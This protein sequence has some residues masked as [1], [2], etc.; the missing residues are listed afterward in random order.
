MTE[1]LFLVDNYITNCEA[2]LLDIR[3]GEGYLDLV[4]DKTPF[5]PGGGGQPADEGMICGINVISVFESDGIVY[6]RIPDS[7]LSL[8]VGAIVQLSVDYEKR[9][10]RMRAHSGE[11]ILSGLAFE[12][13]NTNNVGF[14]MDESGLMTV[15]FDKHLG[16]SEIEMLEYEA[17]KCVMNNKL[18]TINTYSYSEASSLNYRSKI[19]LSKDIR[20]VTIDGIDK[21]ACCA[22]HVKNTGEIGCIKVLSSC[23]HR[24]GVRLTVICGLKAFSE[25]RKRYNQVLKISARLCSKYDEADTAVCELIDNNKKLNLE[26]GKMKLSLLDIIAERIMPSPIIVEFLDGYSIDELRLINNSLKGKYKYAS[27][28]FS[29]FGDKRYN[30]C[31]ISDKLKL[32]LLVRDMNSVFA[33]KGGGKGSVAQGTLYAEKDTIVK[34]LKEL[35]VELYENA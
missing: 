1:K 24:G 26:I 4:F 15:D 2:L 5:F 10:D 25:F 33:G 34:Y 20:I 30:Y 27:F 8:S 28:L 3:Y 13:F 12:L 22:P 31:I 18:I 7:M 29:G 21:C 16:E 14:H 23:S 35:Q 32:G 17:N 9:L 19:E 6:H 11:H